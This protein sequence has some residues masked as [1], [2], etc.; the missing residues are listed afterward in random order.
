[1][2]SRQQ[3]QQQQQKKEKKKKHCPAHLNRVKQMYRTN[4]ISLS[5]FYLVKQNLA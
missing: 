5:D 1:M 4:Q 2:L 3:Q